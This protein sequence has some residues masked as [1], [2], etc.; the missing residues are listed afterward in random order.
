MSHSIRIGIYFFFALFLWTC[1]KHNYEEPLT[2]NPIFYCHGTLDGQAFDIAAGQEEL[3]LS[4][5]IRV[6][7]LGISEW[8]SSFRNASCANCPSKLEVSFFNENQAV[9]DTGVNPFAIGLVRY[10]RQTSEERLSS[11]H[12][13]ATNLSS[14]FSHWSFGDGSIANG[15]EV[16]HIYPSTGSYDVTL[17]VSAFGAEQTV[18]EQTIRAGT[19]DVLA[20]PFDIEV[21][22]SQLAFAML[23]ANLNSYTL[24]PLFWSVNGINVGLVSV[25]EFHPGDEVRLDYQHAENG[26]MGHYTFTAEQFNSEDFAAIEVHRNL[27]WLHGTHARVLYTDDEGALYHSCIDLNDQEHLEVIDVRNGS[28]EWFSGSPS[29]LITLRLS[30]WLVRDDNPNEQIYMENILGDFGFKFEE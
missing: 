22:Q 19:N 4:S 16:N 24:T 8:F 3:Y 29:K 28:E 18:I 25:I 21:Q 9:G 13:H 26:E 5:D 23:P 10:A 20:L 15:H 17:T 2:A 6:N 7:E 27:N 14:G 30:G 11:F 1:Q 12:F